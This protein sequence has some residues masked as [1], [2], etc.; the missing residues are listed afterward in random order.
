MPSAYEENGVRLKLCNGPCGETKETSEFSRQ[1]RGRLMSLCRSCDAGRCRK[2][3]EAN[4]VRI[5]ARKKEYNKRYAPRRR[6]YN[7][8][9]KYGLTVEDYDALMDKQDQLCGCCGDQRTPEINVDHDNTHP[10]NKGFGKKEAVR[11]LLCPTCN[12]TA[13]RLYENGKQMASYLP[14]QEVKAYLANPPAWQLWGV[15]DYIKER[16]LAALAA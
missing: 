15:P 16:E 6:E 10:E 3:N 4:K 8:M 12:Q 7:L 9:Y 1:T 11:G 5:L 2:Y 13:V 14:V